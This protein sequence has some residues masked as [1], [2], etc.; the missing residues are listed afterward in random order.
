M[1]SHSDKKNRIKGLLEPFKISGLS[2]FDVDFTT[3]DAPR[4]RQFEDAL[5]AEALGHRLLQGGGISP[6]PT[7]VGSGTPP[8]GPRLKME[9]SDYFFSA[10]P[11]VKVSRNSKWHSMEE[12]ITHFLFY[13]EGPNLPSGF[14]SGGVEAPKGHLGVT[15][16][17]SGGPK[18]ARARVRSSI[19][20]MAGQ[21]TALVQGAALGDFVVI[22]SGSNIVIGEVD[23]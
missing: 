19:Q 3:A 11:G 13:S 4:S 23:R 16:V 20:I 7:S 12:L 9:L 6:A 22:V 17:S 21:L 15:L 14:S 10:S 8:R 2:G 5:S 1:V 18:V